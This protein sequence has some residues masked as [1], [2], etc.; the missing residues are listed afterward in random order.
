MSAPLG[1]IG[2]FVTGVPIY[3]PIGTS[4]FQ[5]QNIW[6]RDAVAAETKASALLSA[7]NTANGRHS[8]IIG[9]ALDGYPIYGP[10]GRDADGNVRRMRSSYRLRAISKRTTLP[11]GTILTPAQ[12]GPAVG[13]DFPLGFFA[14]D[15]EYAPGSGDLDEF[16]GRFAIT[17][18]Y[19]EGIYA[20]YLAS[21]P[22]SND[23]NGAIAWPYLIGPRYYGDV[24]LNSPAY[25][26]VRTSGR[27]DLRA[28]R[29]RIQPGVAV[30]LSLSIKALLASSA[31]TLAGAG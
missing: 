26:Q 11:D 16:N 27:V 5:D 21:P 4:S 25:R 3:N 29:A 1:I 31:A 12:E 8:P 15:Y 13:A 7:L 2:V 6:H 24:P 28:D 23:D 30:I 14:E 20:Y 10:F 17:P 9:F 19:P 18:E 22:H